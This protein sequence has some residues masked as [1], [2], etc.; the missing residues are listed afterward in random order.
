MPT[1]TAQLHAQVMG[2]SLGPKHYLPVKTVG[3]IE[4]PRKHDSS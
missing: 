1:K 4:R 3:L 2:D